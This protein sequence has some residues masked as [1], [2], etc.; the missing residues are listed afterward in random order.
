MNT[1]QWDGS[2]LELLPDAFMDGDTDWWDEMTQ[3][4]L[5]TQCDISVRGGTQNSNY[6]I[7]FGYND[8]KGV[9][10]GGR[11][12]LLTGRLNFETLIRKQVKLG[13]NLS[14]SSRKTN[15]KD[16]LIDNIIRFRP[17]F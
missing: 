14:G 3:N 8:Q 4:A 17:D 16:N 11:S 2:M 5:T 9:V 7:S 10:K 15:N 12:K 1:S 6:F 13:V